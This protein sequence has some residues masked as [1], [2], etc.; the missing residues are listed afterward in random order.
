VFKKEIAAIMRLATVT[1]VSATERIFCVKNKQHFI[2][3]NVS[4]WLEAWTGGIENMDI[5]NERSSLCCHQKM[6]P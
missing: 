3:N 2:T 1:G 5:R 6:I 4:W